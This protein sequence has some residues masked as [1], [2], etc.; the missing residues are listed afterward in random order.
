MFVTM[1][2]DYDFGVPVFCFTDA[3][4]TTECIIEGAERLDGFRANLFDEGTNY[5]RPLEINGEF[6]IENPEELEKIIFESLY[7]KKVDALVSKLNDEWRDKFY[8]NV[9]VQPVWKDVQPIIDEFEKAYE[10]TLP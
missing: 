4:T 2:E 9:K 5:G 7:G 6:E 3:N 8:K 10:Q 1:G